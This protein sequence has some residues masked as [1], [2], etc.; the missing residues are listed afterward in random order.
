MI[1]IAAGFLYQAVLLYG[2]G[3]LCV[4]LL[5]RL[6]GVSDT[7]THFFQ[8]CIFGYLLLVIVLYALH[9]F[10]PVNGGVFIALSLLSVFGYLLRD[11]KADIPP[12]E[13]PAVFLFVALVLIVFC[14]TISTL[15][16]QN[17]VT[18][19]SML[20]H[21]NW[22]KWANEYAAVPGLANLHN[23]LGM[24]SAFLLYSS[25]LDNLWW[26]D[27]SAWL[28]NGFFLFLASA[29][30]LRVILN[31]K[32]PATLRMY[33]LLT[34]P[35]FLRLLLTLEPGLQ[36]DFASNVLVL[37]LI[38]EFIRHYERAE[39]EP[40]NLA[41]LVALSYLSLANK[42]SG[43]PVAA[44]ITLFA[45]WHPL[46]KNLRSF[47]AAFSLPV[48]MVLL[49]LAW[50]GILSGWLLYPLPHVDVLEVDWKTPRPL[51]EDLYSAIV[52][53]A[54]LPGEKYATAYGSEI[55]YW[56][57]AWFQRY[58]S[59]Y[60]FYLLL[61]GFLM[62]V[63]WGALRIL[64]RKSEENDALVGLAIFNML[65]IV[66]WFFSAPDP[67]FAEHLFWS[68]LAL[69]TV[70]VAGQLTL[71]RTLLTKYPAH[72]LIAF[73][74]IMSFLKG[75][76]FKYTPVLLEPPAAKTAPVHT[77]VLRN[78]Q[79]P[80]LKV[81]IPVEGDQCGNSELPCTPYPDHNLKLRKP[82]VLRN[83]FRY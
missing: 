61:A 39:A 42:L 3:L 21:L 58:S 25:F 14:S 27:R 71:A 75:G 83:G 6:G 82:G 20:Y 4:F 15:A 28:T 50:N 62:F 63:L 57:P 1:S 33:S 72:I 48:L 55:S 53:W 24:N 68:C 37:T 2:Y 19:D 44:A 23:R 79:N 56:F 47:T 54:R 34:F 78:G 22:V 41:Y 12:I 67:R 29:H 11:K 10:I 8:T 13:K 49:F 32:L 35:Y 52:G 17:K 74:G 45:L 7:R 66:F 69:S 59:H 77:I 73:I 30:W 46:R 5:K 9:F 26:N 65:C 16:G 38:A 64:R 51:I 36:Y 31:S 81:L 43:A 60:T 80:P 76:F 40:L 70:L 18:G